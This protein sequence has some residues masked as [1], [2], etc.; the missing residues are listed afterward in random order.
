LNEEKDIFSSVKDNKMRSPLHYA[1][2]S[3]S[4]ECCEELLNEQL[5]LPIDQKDSF[6]Q[7]PLICAAGCRSGLLEIG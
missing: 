3:G 4:L 6:G 1:A 5:G 2:S 7:T